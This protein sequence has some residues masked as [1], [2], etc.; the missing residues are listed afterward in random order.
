MS[1][2]A[3]VCSPANRGARSRISPVIRDRALPEGSAALELID[4]GDRHLQDHLHFVE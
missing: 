4:F 1:I 2:V 3:P